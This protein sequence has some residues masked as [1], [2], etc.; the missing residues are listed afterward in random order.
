MMLPVDEPERTVVENWIWKK[1][2][3]RLKP[4]FPLKSVSCSEKVSSDFA[5]PPKSEVMNRLKPVKRPE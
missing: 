4:S 3:S 1:R 5:K 2:K